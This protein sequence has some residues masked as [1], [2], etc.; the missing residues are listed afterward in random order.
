MGWVGCSGKK[1]VGHMTAVEHPLTGKIISYNFFNFS[2][3]A[4]YPSIFQGTPHPNPPS[5]IPHP[6][7][8]TDRSDPWW[9]TLIPRFVSLSL[10][11][12]LL[13]SFLLFL[14]IFYPSCLFFLG[15]RLGSAGSLADSPHHPPN[16]RPQNRPCPP[17]GQRRHLRFRCPHHRRITE[18]LL[19]GVQ[20]TGLQSDPSVDGPPLRPRISR[21]YGERFG[22][23]D[24]GCG[25]HG[26][27]P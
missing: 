20:H 15:S 18:L 13:F 11:P 6:P 26:V 4:P 25:R 10:V 2:D 1:I 16:L 17:L 22:S 3:T 19:S 5:P 12:F 7:A 27:L 9:I 14:G 24:N 23:H 8:S 21:H